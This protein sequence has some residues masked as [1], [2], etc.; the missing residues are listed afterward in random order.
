MNSPQ[1]SLLSPLSKE[2]GLAKVGQKNLKP[3]IPIIGLV[4][5]NQNITENDTRWQEVPPGHRKNKKKRTFFRLLLI[6]F[7]GCLL[8]R[9]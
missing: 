1:S 3:R 8:N 7:I 4:T 6:S 5:Q 9:A 2:R